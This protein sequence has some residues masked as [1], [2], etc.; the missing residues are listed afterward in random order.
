[1]ADIAH[2][3]VELAAK[4]LVFPGMWLVYFVYSWAT[5]RNV[6]A[7]KRR[8]GVRPRIVRAISLACVAALIGLPHFP[9]AV[10]SRR[11]IPAGA[12]TFWSGAVLTAFGLLFSLWGRHHLGQNW[13]VAVTVKEGHELITSGPYALV[14]HPLYAGLVV[15]L[16]GCVVAVGEWRGLLAMALAISVFW[17][18]LRLEERWM[19]EQFGES[20]EAYSRRVAALVPYIL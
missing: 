3:T 5:L 8:E 14:R 18:K 20:Y 15:A 9:V 19:R 12:W 4:R 6:R 11:F 17:T 10:L 2:M 7:V 13:S 1:M 16:L